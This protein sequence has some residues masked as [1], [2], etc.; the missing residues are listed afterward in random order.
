M[1]VSP[2]PAPPRKRRSAGRDL[3]AAIAVGVGLV[4]A[5]VA[6]L[7]W[8]HWGFILIVAVMLSLGAI[9]IGTALRRIG[10][11]AAVTP[12]VLGTFGMIVA[13]YAAATGVGL[14]PVPW[15]AVLL[16]FLG[17][18]ILAALIARFPAGHENFVHDASAS[19]FIIGYV[20]LLGSFS[21]L[22]LA[23]DN[24][25]GRMVAFLLC[26]VGSDTG[27]YIVGVL[28]GRTPL[29]PKISPKKTV[30]GAVGSVLLA[31]A[32]GAAMAEFVLRVD[33]WVGVLLGLV[34]VFFG[35]C[36]DLIES[37]IKRDV[38]IKDMSSMLPGHGGIMDRLDSMLVAGA[39]AWLVMLLF[40]PGG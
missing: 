12:I 10:M 39:P 15:H 26:V 27:G 4:V 25:A 13:T 24:G 5:V 11:N 20:G 33:W 28:F 34:C 17:A 2:P 1:S 31:C 21:A 7:I 16:S 37:S 35:T 6:S 19:L 23:G 22:I 9:E 30:E 38:G 32:V 36:G 29:A 8:W 40:V 18:T 3:P 14:V